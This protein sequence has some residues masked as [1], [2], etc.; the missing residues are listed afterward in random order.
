MSRYILVFLS[1]VL[2][3]NQLT[4]Q[5]ILTKAQAIQITLENNFAIQMA[6]ND[7]EVAKNNTSKELNGYLPTINATAGLNSRLG[8]SSQKFFNGNENTTSNAFNWGTN[9][10]V[11][12]NYTIVDK[13]RD[14]TTHKEQSL[15][16]WKR[17]VNGH[18]AIFTVILFKTHRYLIC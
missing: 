6:K 17:L 18:R 5:N 15:R 14:L 1:W 2:S 9:A 10:T 4:A 7:I 12:A 16:I 13:T 3:I 11:Q 8:G